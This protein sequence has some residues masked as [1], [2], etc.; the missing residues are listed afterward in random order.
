SI[1]NIMTA[2]VAIEHSNLTDKTIRRKQAAGLGENIMGI[3]EG[4]EYELEELL[5]GLIL[6]SGN[7]SAIAVAEQ[8]AGSEEV[9]VNWLNI[10]AS[11][12]GLS[13]T[14]FTDSSGLNDST[15][16]TAYDLAVLTRYAL[17]NPDFKKLVSTVDY[18]IPSTNEHRY[19]ALSNQTN[20]L[21]TYPGVKGVKTG[22]TE[23]AGLCLVSYAEN[24]GHK[25]VGIVLNSDARKTDMIQ[26]LDYSF[27]KVGVKISHPLLDL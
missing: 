21:T 15:Y 23:A 20:L 12:L 5:Y 17:K 27:E 6:H 24:D 16:S 8:V 19:L 26:L 22:Y 1:T 25:I 3:S 9:F 14:K 18:E 2:V 11:E 10:K 4:E 7:D 13:D